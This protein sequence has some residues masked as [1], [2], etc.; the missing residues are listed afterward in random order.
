MRRR[1]A[2]LLLAA[3]GLWACDDDA[4]DPGIETHPDVGD[5]SARYPPW[6]AA[7]DVPPP[8]AAL[9][10]PPMVTI[11]PRAVTLVEGRPPRSISILMHGELEEA[12]TVRVSTSVGVVEPAEVTFAV[13][14]PRAAMVQLRAPFDDDEQNDRGVLLASFGADDVEA[15]VVV[16]DVHN[17]LEL[18]FDADQ[19]AFVESSRDK[20]RRLVVDTRLAG[21]P[22]PSAEV[23]LRGKG[24]LNCARRSFT[25]RFDQPA[26]IRDSPPLE[27][28]LLLSMCLDSTYLK[29]R[30]SVEVLQGL[31]LFPAW[32]SYVE[33]RYGGQSR[34]VYLMVERPRKAIPRVF[35]ENQVVVRR[36]RDNMEEVKRPSVE[37]IEDLDAF[38]APYRR[39]Y[40]LRRE[41]E[42]E[43]LLAALRSHLDY[44]NYLRWLA[45]NSVLRNGDYI[46]EVYFYDRRGPA[47]AMRPYFAVMAWDYDDILKG[48][49][50]R[51]PLPE[52]LFYCAESSLDRPV[53]NHAVVRRVYVDIL[54][55]VMSEALSVEAY[56][57]LLTRTAGELSVYLRREGV[58]DA[59][60][61]DREDMSPPPEPVDAVAEM[62]EL[63]GA[64]HAELESLLP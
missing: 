29:M 59:M 61:V 23:N 20:A 14:G 18:A 38:L 62:L 52:P 47:G 55:S 32:F 64:R 46:D 9:V 49:H 58:A 16:V 50:N 3:C 33:L 26:Y 15:P 42:G 10:G 22:A 54:R 57:T 36:I 48:C 7:P 31:G 21:R 41:F 30:T 63:M 17:T 60:R 2:W 39:L 37:T 45:V 6:D 13:D 44:D 4:A 53:M 25:V 1:S 12:V 8:D 56:E 43:A 11:E 35:P 5:M 51:G 19:I 28:V 40:E 24:T 27:H 34:G